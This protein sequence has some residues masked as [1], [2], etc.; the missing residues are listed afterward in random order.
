MKKILIVDDNSNNRMLLQ[1]MLEDFAHENDNTDLKVDQVENGLEAV[2]AAAKE[3]YDIIFMDIMMPEM[4]GIEATHR[5]RQNDNNVLIV[6]VSAV[7][8]AGRQREILQKG[9]EDYISKPVNAD[10][11]QSRIGNY[12]TLA[13]SR[14]HPKHYKKAVNLYSHEVFSRQLIFTVESEDD[15]SEFWEYY[16]LESGSG[17]E[18]LSDV[19]RTLYA[20]GDVA[21]RCGLEPKIIM[22]ESENEMYFSLSEIGALDAKLIKLVMAKNSAVTDYVQESHRMSF[23]VFKEDCAITPD[24]MLTV[25]PVVET[26]PAVEEAEVETFAATPIMT[27]DVPTQVYDYMDHDDLEEIRL[28]I[29]KLDS[30]FLLVGKGELDPSEAEEIYTYIDRIGSMMTIYAET[31]NIGQALGTLASDIAT[32]VNTFIE[33]S[34]MLG[35]MCAA[36]S[37]D[38]SS[39]LRLTFEE[40][41]TSVDFM[42]DTIIANAKTIG[43][44]LTMDDAPAGDDGDLDDI[45]DF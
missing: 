24:A 18:Q 32:H 13:E 20:L 25:A 12:L 7:D 41:S 37:S 45:F 30:L 9:A 6:A 19:V 21:L 43:G 14:R 17:C 4:D 34:T 36:F 42:D 2:E 28:Y 5:I 26:A 39:W 11:F 10:I 16:L 8:D 40:G 23:R 15:L 27:S 29:G 22:E 35:P 44:M 3:A 31:Y 1:V 38:L 33:K